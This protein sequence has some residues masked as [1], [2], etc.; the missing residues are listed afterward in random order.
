MRHPELSTW[1]MRLHTRRRTRSSWGAPKHVL[2]CCIV[3]AHRRLVFVWGAI[4]G[5][6]VYVCVCVV[7]ATGKLWW[8]AHNKRAVETKGDIYLSGVCRR[9]VRAKG[10][11][12]RRNIYLWCEL[13]W[14]T[15][16]MMWKC[17]FGI[18]EGYFHVWTC[19]LVMHLE[20]LG[21]VFLWC[22]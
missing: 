5:W 20:G 21:E 10:V 18:C 12:M 15:T 17:V 7:V 14:Y 9:C 1:E 3:V 19:K 2:C 22:G 11:E 4:N 6:G 8:E 16:A 13:A